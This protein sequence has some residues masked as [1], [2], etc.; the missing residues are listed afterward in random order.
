MKVT[1]FTLFRKYLGMLIKSSF[2]YKANAFFLSFGVFIRELVNVLIMFLLLKKFGDINGWTLYEMLFLYSLIYLSYSILVGFFAG[3]RNFPHFIHSGSLDKYLTKPMGVLFQVI[4]TQADYFA[5]IGHGIIGFSLFFYSA[6]LIGL[7]WT[8]LYIGYYLLA[9]IGGVLIQLSIWLFTASLS[10]WTVKSESII[11]F[12]FWNGRKFSGYP[13]SIFPGFIKFLLMF[14][15]PFAFVNYFPAQFFLRKPDL[16]DFWPGFI[17][18]TPV[19]GVLLFIGVM[20]FWRFSI[21][22]YSSTGTSNGV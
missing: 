2:Q 20:F 6:E 16:Q 5:S 22:H 4:S 12:I 7:V 19:V 3:I 8:P 11:G 10:I 14:I 15:I 9:I 21:R 1:S 17:Y 18:L 13:L